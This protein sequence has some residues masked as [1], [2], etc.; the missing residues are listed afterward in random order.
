MFI[1]GIA[2]LAAGC[3]GAA[4]FVAAPGEAARE[5][6]RPGRIVPQRSIDVLVLGVRPATVRARFGKRQRVRH[7]SES[8]SGKPITAWVYSRRKIVAS[9]RHVKSKRMTLAEISTTSR[10]Q[11]TQ[12]G[13]RIG[14]TESTLKEKVAGLDCGDADAERWCTIGRG[15][16][17]GKP[18]TVFVLRRDRLREVRIVLIF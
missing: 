18:Q 3:L 4:I 5:G 10:R 6:A 17:H 11:R 15:L 8:G 12:S 1:S 14:I 2:L 13:A 9:F 7:L 16:V